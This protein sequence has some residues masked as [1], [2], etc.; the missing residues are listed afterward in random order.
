M[1]RFLIHFLLLKIKDVGKG[2]G[3][4]L[5]IVYGIVKQNNGFINVYSEKGHGSTFRIY[6]PKHD[7]T[8]EI[9]GTDTVDERPMGKGERVLVVEDEISLLR[10]V[11]MMLERLG[12]TVITTHSPSDAIK[13]IQTK[14]RSIDVLLTDLVMPQMSGVELYNKAKSYK[15][16]LKC[17]FMSGYTDI[18]LF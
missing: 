8:G 6:L 16:D 1:I 7:S 10:M 14:A 3:L 15:N 2:T 17:L 9:K 11:K 5:S 18:I 4:G 13:I 12:Y